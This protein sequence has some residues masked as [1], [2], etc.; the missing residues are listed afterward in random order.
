ML[1][2]N[3]CFVWVALVITLGHVKDKIVNTRNLGRGLGVGLFKVA[4]L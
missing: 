4:M 1:E 2:I 3:F